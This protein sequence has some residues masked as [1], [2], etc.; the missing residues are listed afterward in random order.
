MLR[1]QEVV[2]GGG[3]WLAIIGGLLSISVQKKIIN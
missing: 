2:V 1:P 3:C